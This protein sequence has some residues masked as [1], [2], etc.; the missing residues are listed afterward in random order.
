MRDSN[1]ETKAKRNLLEFRK[2]YLNTVFSIGTGISLIILIV[3]HF[4]VRYMVE[5]VVL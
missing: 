3:S 5:S 2:S 4:P 1:N